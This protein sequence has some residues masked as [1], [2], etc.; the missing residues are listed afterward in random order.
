MNIIDQSVGR[1][2]LEEA[3]QTLLSVEGCDASN[4][5][6]RDKLLSLEKKLNSNQ[7]HLAVSGKRSGARVPSSTRSWELTFC[8]QGLAGDCDHHGNQVRAGHRGSD[9]IYHGTA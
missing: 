9:P 5:G 3:L 2:S 8:R 4:Q 7:L 1:H 6:L